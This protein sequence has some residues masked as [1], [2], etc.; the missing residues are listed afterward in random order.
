LALIL[1]KSGGRSVGIAHSRTKATELIGW[2]SVWN[3]RPKY[4]LIRV[5]TANN[6]MPLLS[7][8]SYYHSNYAYYVPCYD[9]AVPRSVLETRKREDEVIKKPLQKTSWNFSGMTS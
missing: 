5:F 7:T 6:I 8:R 1:P 9:T 2:Y 3:V 4:Q